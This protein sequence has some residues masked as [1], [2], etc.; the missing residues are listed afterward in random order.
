MNKKLVFFRCFYILHKGK[1]A[2]KNLVNLDEGSKP[3]REEVIT[4]V[5]HPG[6]RGHKYFFC[7]SYQRLWRRIYCVTYLQLKLYN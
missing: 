1:A 6:K 7:E 2:M 3:L 4:S 5:L